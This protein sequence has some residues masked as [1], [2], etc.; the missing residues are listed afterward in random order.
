[1]TNFPEAPLALKAS[2]Y[3]FMIHLHQ[4]RTFHYKLLYLPS[5]QPVSLL[6]EAIMKASAYYLYAKILP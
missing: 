1:M 5:S 4:N 2:A 6:R 3:P